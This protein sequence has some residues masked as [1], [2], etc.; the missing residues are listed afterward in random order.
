MPNVKKSPQAVPEISHPHKWDELTIQKH[1]ASNHGYLQCR[2]LLMCGEKRK[3]RAIM[4]NTRSR[5]TTGGAGDGRKGWGRTGWLRD[6]SSLL[7]RKVK[8]FCGCVWEHGGVGF[9]EGLV[10]WNRTRVVKHLPGKL[11]A[12]S[13]WH[14]IMSETYTAVCNPRQREAHICWR[15]NPSRIFF[16]FFVEIQ[17]HV[18]AYVRKSSCFT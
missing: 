8:F 6:N 12:W 1:N 15:E 10:E 4:K 17:I 16:F 11:I 3:V 9:W 2:Q 5:D 13:L 14:L 7:R 18:V